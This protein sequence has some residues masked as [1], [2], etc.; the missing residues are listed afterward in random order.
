MERETMDNHL[1]VA[2]ATALASNKGIE[3]RST[4]ARLVFIRD[5]KEIG[6]TLIMIEAAEPWIARHAFDR[7][8][9]TD[10]HA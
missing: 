4:G 7:I 8:T 9:E 10:D 1:T 5:G 6:S 3:T 2:I